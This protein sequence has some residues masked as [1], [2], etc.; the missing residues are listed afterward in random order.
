MKH[1]KAIYFS[2]LVLLGQG[3]VAQ[4]DKDYIEFNDRYNVV[5]GVYLGLT[6]HYGEIDSENSYMMGLKAAYVADQ[7]L[8]IGLVGVAF[9]SEQDEFGLDANE[10]DIYGGYGGLHLEPILFRHSKFS[11]SFPLLLGGGTVGY[12]KDDFSGRDNPDTGDNGNWPN[13]FIAEPGI[14]VL[15]NFSRYVQL[16]VGGRYRLTSRFTMLPGSPVDL[17]G[18]SFGFG[19]KVGV[20]NLGRNRYQKQL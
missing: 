11:L 2:I 4:N 12:G 1:Q 13:F 6:T 7:K 10:F 20:F 15:F 8:E 9:Y 16:E 14:N 5:H 18:F 19:L 3:L 17:N